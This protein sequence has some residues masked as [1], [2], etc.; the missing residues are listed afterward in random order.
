GGDLYEVGVSSD[1]PH[2]AAVSL[3]IDG[4]DVFT[5]SD[6]KDEKTGRPRYS[7][8]IVGPGQDFTVVGWHR[9]NDRADSFRVT[10]FADSAAAKLLRG[11]SS[12]GTITVGFHAAWTGDTPPDDE[13]GARDAGDATG[14]GPPRK[15]ELKQVQRH[16]GVLRDAVSVRYTRR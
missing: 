6:V 1:G 12:V 16:V 4:L 10:S 11:S 5:F 7:Y 14:F 15:T 3:S 8:F 2:E 9:T 13:K